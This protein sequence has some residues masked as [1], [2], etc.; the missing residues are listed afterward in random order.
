MLVRSSGITFNIAMN[1]ASICW[2]LRARAINAWPDAA[3]WH[4][5]GRSAAMAVASPSAVKYHINSQLCLQQFM[6][7]AHN[8]LR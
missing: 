4:L 6:P 5:D 1:S 2:R 8:D 7:M 3:S